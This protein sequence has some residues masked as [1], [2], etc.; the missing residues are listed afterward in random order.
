MQ[1]NI[2]DFNIKKSIYNLDRQRLFSNIYENIHGLA[3]LLECV[4]NLILSDKAKIQAKKLKNKPQCKLWEGYEKYLISHIIE[5]YDRWYEE[6]ADKEKT[7]YYGTVNYKNIEILLEKLNTWIFPDF[8]PDWVTSEVIQIHRSHLIQKE[9]EK[10]DDFDCDTYGD[11]FCKKEKCRQCDG[12]DYNGEPNGYGCNAR[13][14]FI[15][16]KYKELHHYRTLWPKC[17]RDLKMRYDW[18]IK[19]E[20]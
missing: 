18:R 11:K 17:P 4:D 13:D 1:T 9:I 20:T 3:C 10:E 15:E 7:K 5:A 8:Y 2:T 12:T 14:N 6:F 16:C 19:Y